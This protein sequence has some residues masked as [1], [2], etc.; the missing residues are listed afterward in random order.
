MEL[1]AGV[2]E[3]GRGAVIGPLVVAGVLA[4]SHHIEKF[5]RLGIKDSKDLT[6]KRREYLAKKIEKIA[7]DIFVL[8]IG[9]CKIDNY[10]NIYTNLNKLEIV[11]FAEIIKFLSPS[12]AYIDAPENPEKLKNILQKIV[13]DDIDLVVEHYADST[14]PIVSSASIIAKVA[15]DNEIKKLKKKYGDIGSGYPAD[16]ITI[17]FLK[18]WLEK[19]K[20]FPDIVR[21]TWETVKILKNDKKQSKLINWFK[22]T[23]DCV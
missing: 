3:A 12:K 7:K 21:K 16:P 8:K 17:N 5:K 1:I 20:N 13:G 15:R 2:D 11:K 4:E 19:N 23:K 18:T 22:R 10:R 14:Y 6:P 9:P